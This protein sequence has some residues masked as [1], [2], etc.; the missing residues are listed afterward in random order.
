MAE[1]FLEGFETSVF[2]ILD[3]SGFLLL[4]PCMDYK[5]ANEGNTG[6]NTGGMGSICP[7][8]LLDAKAQER[9]RKEVVEPTIEG[10]RKDNLF[11][12]GILYFGLMMTPS[13]P[14]VLEYNVR[15]GDPETQSLLPLMTSDFCSLWDAVCAGKVSTFQLGLSDKAALGVVVASPGYPGKYPKRLVVEIK[16]RPEDKNLLIFHAA[17]RGGTTAR[18]SPAEGDALPLSG[19]GKTSSRPLRRPTAGSV[20]FTS[21]ELGTGKTSERESSRTRSP[22]SSAAGGLRRAECRRPRRR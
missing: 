16:D 11:Y 10:L 20:A 15:F 21:E 7:V 1:E 2:A 3:G 9:I 18:S 6:P 8:P 19:S 14:K 4:P 22:E 13:G 17:R 12:K 5:K